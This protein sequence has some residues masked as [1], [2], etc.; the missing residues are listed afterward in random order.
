MIHLIPGAEQ[1]CT[2]VSERTSASHF[3][4]LCLAKIMRS[5][6]NQVETAARPMQLRAEKTDVR[7]VVMRSYPR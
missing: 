3:W 4:P 6:M 2:F 7:V 1:I 5:E